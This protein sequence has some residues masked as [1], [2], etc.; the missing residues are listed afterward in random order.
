[1]NIILRNIAAFS[2]SHKLIFSIFVLCQ[3]ITFISVFYIA[4]VFTSTQKYIADSNLAYRTFTVYTDNDGDKIAKNIKVILSQSQELSTVKVYLDKQRLQAN[5]LYPPENE[6][7]VLVGDYFTEDA[8]SS[9]NSQIIINEDASEFKVGNIIQ[10]QDMIFEVIGL[11]YNI[12]NYSEVPYTAL[13][14]LSDITRIS[15][16]LKKIPRATQK[17]EFLALLQATF[18]NQEIS[19]P[20]SID[21]IT[22]SGGTIEYFICIL[23][24]ALAF[25]NLSYLYSYILNCR[26][27]DF[28]VMRLTGCSAKKAYALLFGE[29]SIISSVMCFFSCAFLSFFIAPFFAKLNGNVTYSI[30]IREYLIFYLISILG[31]FV[32]FHGVIHKYTSRSI[33]KLL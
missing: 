17:A 15:F 13:S 18:P 22:V 21:V 29:I 6:R 23:V 4:A 5:V 31:I 24:M 3:F 28:I 8:F 33:S 26:E 14:D 9:G 25:L 30:S 1:M 10:I 19:E 7:Y 16:T 20:D 2:K 32:V 11:N 12:G 27:T